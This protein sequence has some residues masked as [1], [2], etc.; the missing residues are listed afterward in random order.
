MSVQEQ[1][2]LREELQAVT[3]RL[4]TV[5]EDERRILSRELHD[6]IGQAITAIK[7]G[8]M[9]L[10]EDDDPARRAEI[11]ADIIA[12]SDQ[13]VAKLRNL[14]LLLRPPQ[15]DTLG[16]EAALR[17]QA[18]ALFRAGRPRL[19]LDM[20]ALPQRLR[21]EVELACFRIAQEALTNIL[22]HARADRV[23]L[24]LAPDAQ[25]RCVQLAIHD[26]GQGFDPG[27]AARGLGLV[28]MRERA[29]QLGGTLVVESDR[30][31]GT[32]VRARLPMGGSG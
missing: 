28:T 13:T 26:D 12:T 23:T 16:L 11:V 27:H 4:L 5:Q 19:E 8:A 18:D 22:R 6:D 32:C 21:P 3:R 17:W 20:A 24:T 25:G 14:S 2:L 29:Q 30:G 15:L 31:H 10:Q 9:S 7:L 1:R